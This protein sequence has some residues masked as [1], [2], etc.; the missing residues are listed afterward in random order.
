MQ[1]KEEEKKFVDMVRQYEAIIYKVTSFY[2]NQ[3]QSISDLYQEVVLN[4]WKAYPSFRGES[5][6][7]TWIYRIALNTCIT[8]FRRTQ[9][10]PVYVDISMDISEVDTS[11]ED[12]KELYR[13]I[14]LLGK[15]ERALILLYLDEKSYKEIAEITGLSVTNVATKLSRIKDKLRDMSDKDN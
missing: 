6:L 13:L 4:L 12:I 14:N 1:H 5:K 10:Q 9:K 8:F 11:N 7:S 15:I 3:S 2:A